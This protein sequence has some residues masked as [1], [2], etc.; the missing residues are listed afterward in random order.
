MLFV[1][2]RLK[3]DQIIEVSLKQLAI[4]RHKL[5]FL[6]EYLINNHNRNHYLNENNH[7]DN[8]YSNENNHHDN[9]CQNDSI[10]H[11]NRNLNDNDHLD[12]HYLLSKWKNFNSRICYT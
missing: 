10:H 1:A 5:S 4:E 7:H 2:R 8:H 11:E 9:H 3:S 12:N 6:L